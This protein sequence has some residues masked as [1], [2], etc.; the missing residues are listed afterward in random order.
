MGTISRR[1]RKKPVFRE[2]TRFSNVR[3][4]IRGAA[5]CKRDSR[6]RLRETKRKACAGKKVTFH[7]CKRVKKKLAGEHTLH[8]EFLYTVG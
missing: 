2:W 7:D 5:L 8:N 1:K 6:S 4:L 3:Q